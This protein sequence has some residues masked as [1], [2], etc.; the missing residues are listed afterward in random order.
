[1]DNETISHGVVATILI[2]PLVTVVNII[3]AA[4][5]C[6]LAFFFVRRFVKILGSVG[7]KVKEKTKKFGGEVK[8]EASRLRTE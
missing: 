6:F 7:T 1:M 8:Q 2:I 4:T 3:L 5:G